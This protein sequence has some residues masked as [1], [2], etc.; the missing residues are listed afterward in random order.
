MQTLES[1]INKGTHLS[2]PRKRKI[3]DSQQQTVQNEQEIDKSSIIRQF[4]LAC[5]KLILRSL[6]YARWVL[7]FQMKNL[8]LLIYIN[9]YLS[10]NYG[11]GGQMKAK[12]I[13]LNMTYQTYL[14]Q[15]RNLL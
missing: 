5:Q 8:K 9:Y 10:A 13:A 4:D 12:L 2:S 7:I 1:N 15:C 3:D 14:P 11:S 6:R